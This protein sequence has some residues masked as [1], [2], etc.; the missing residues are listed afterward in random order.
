MCG[1]KLFIYFMAA[2]LVMIFLGICLAILSIPFVVFMW[3]WNLVLP[4]L[5]GFPTID[6]WQAIGIFILLSFFASLVG[7]ARS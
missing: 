6:F 2:I 1:V 5:L 7:R 4:H 3:A